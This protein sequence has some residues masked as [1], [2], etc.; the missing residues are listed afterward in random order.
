MFELLFKGGDA[1]NRSSLTAVLLDVVKTYTLAD[2]HIS[3]VTRSVRIIDNLTGMDITEFNSR[4]GTEI[5]IKRF[6][7]CFL[8][9]IYFDN[10]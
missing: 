5:I 10:D 2:H 7:V 8:E 9:E 6:T 3:F 4:D 1:L